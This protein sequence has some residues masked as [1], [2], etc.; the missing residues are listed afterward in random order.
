MT[1][2]RV[3]VD[4]LPIVLI[5]V[6]LASAA[7]G[8]F[9]ADTA[10]TSWLRVAK[11]VTTILLLVVVG[12]PRTRFAWLIDLGILFAL[13]GDVAL[14]SV[15]TNAFLVGLG[16]FLVTHGSYIFA[17]AGAAAHG[18]TVA[19]ASGAGFWSPV[20]IGAALTM[21]TVTVLL[22]RQLWVGAAGLRGPL[23]GYALALGAMVVTAV[24]AVGGRPSSTSMT[25]GAAVSP[26]AAVGAVLFYI[27]DA[28][29]ALDRFRRPIK[30]APILTLGVYWLGQLGIA[31]AARLVIT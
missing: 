13:A 23:V 5:V 4:P 6:F 15:R 3:V 14:L 2:S 17:F 20:V 30:H 10:R 21:A 26:V 16:L 22:L 12:W 24:A 8:V 29:L 25:A 31:L 1:V 7:F 18:A 27:A 11:P 28:S 9:A 19:D